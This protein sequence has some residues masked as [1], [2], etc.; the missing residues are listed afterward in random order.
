MHRTQQHRQFVHASSL[1]GCAIA[2]EVKGLPFVPA[3]QPA[4]HLHRSSQL[5]RAASADTEMLAWFAGQ[6][7]V[8]QGPCHQTVGTMAQPPVHGER[9]PKAG[10]GSHRVAARL[11][12][13]TS[14]HTKQHLPSL[15]TPPRVPPPSGHGKHLCDIQTAHFSGQVPSLFCHQYSVS[16][17]CT[18]GSRQP[19]H[20]PV[21]NTQ[22]WVTGMG[23][24]VF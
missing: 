20:N 23:D 1:L 13:D 16:T 21:M 24:T 7:Q 17:H 22:R 19:I 8:S 18:A 9:Q 14:A 6:H 3:A 11:L 15:L 12:T 5:R 4:H 2:S 10:Q